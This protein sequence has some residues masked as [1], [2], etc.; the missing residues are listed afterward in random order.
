[1]PKTVK[2]K[3]KLAKT[4]AKPISKPKVKVKPRSKQKIKVA[5]SMP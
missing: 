5:V 4:K 3:K 2:A 1:M